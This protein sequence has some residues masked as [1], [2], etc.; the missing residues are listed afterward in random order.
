MIICFQ[1]IAF[2][3]SV[4]MFHIKQITGD[5]RSSI[6]NRTRPSD[7][8]GCTGTARRASTGIAFGSRRR[9]GSAGFSDCK[10]LNITEGPVASQI[11]VSGIAIIDGSNLKSILPTGLNNL[12]LRS[13]VGRLEGILK[14]SGVVGT[15][16]HQVGTATAPLIHP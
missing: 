10:D 8:D 1:R 4:G 12:T 3:S 7:C 6:I 11:S 9:Q 2:Q 16:V 5:G 15:I 13:N 14:C